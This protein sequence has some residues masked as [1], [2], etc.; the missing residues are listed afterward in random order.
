MLDLVA[1]LSCQGCGIGFKMLH[2]L[3]HVAY[4]ACYA[5]ISAQYRTTHELIKL[6]G[7]DNCILDDAVSVLNVTLRNKSLQ[8]NSAQGTSFSHRS[9]DIAWTHLASLA[10]WLFWD[11]QKNQNYHYYDID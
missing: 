11:S 4:F 6:L 5:R 2:M 9:D 1:F 8:Q 3:I 10:P 7:T